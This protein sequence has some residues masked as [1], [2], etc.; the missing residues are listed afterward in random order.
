MTR[1]YAED[2]SVPTERSA[3]EIERM[4]ARHGAS[5]FMRG[6]DAD[7]AVIQFVLEGKRVRFDLPMPALEDFATTEAGRARKGAAAE[8]ARDQEVRRRWRAL[9]L[10]VKA[11]LEA[12]QSGVMSFES[13][14]LSY[15][16]TPGGS[17][18]GAIVLPQLRDSLEGRAAPKLLGARS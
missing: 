16:V 8:T 12:V 6:W 9:A 4:L 11:K 14:F 5:Q 13:E 2:T 3:A 10:V 7:R 18:V 15:F 1:R 17:T